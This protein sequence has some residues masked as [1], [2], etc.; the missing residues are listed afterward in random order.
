MEEEEFKAYMTEGKPPEYDYELAIS[1]AYQKINSPALDKS[2][3][4]KYREVFWLGAMAGEAASISKISRLLPA[5]RFL[6]DMN[7]VPG[8]AW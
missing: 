2:A 3:L 8:D 4:E 1:L 6:L 7:R 5:A